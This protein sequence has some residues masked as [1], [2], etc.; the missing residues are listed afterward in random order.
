MCSSFDIYFDF[1]FVSFDIYFSYVINVPNSIKILR[2]YT[3]RY[4]LFIWIIY[5]LETEKQKHFF[6]FTTSMAFILIASDHDKI[7]IFVFCFCYQNVKEVCRVTIDVQFIF[8]YEDWIALISFR[9]RA[10]YKKN[11]IM[12]LANNTCSLTLRNIEWKFSF[13]AQI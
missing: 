13:Q 10:L 7:I 12:N 9:I 8:R 2:E 5:F 4:C 11:L 3:Q 6:C 1:L